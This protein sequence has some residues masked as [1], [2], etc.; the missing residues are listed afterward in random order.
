MN[1]ASKQY[2]SKNT[3]KEFDQNLEYVKFS[4][5]GFQSYNKYSSLFMC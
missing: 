3:L 2:N 4:V 5:S 1:N